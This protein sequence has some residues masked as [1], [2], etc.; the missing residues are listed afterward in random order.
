MTTKEAFLHITPL[1]VFGRPERDAN[2]ETETGDD[3]LVDSNRRT[4]K[5]IATADA[6]ELTWDEV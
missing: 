5:E 6:E 2:S 3:Q 4:P 1:D